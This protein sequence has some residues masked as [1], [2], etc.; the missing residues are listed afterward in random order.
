M[1][2]Y[3][4]RRALPFLVLALLYVIITLLFYSNELTGDELRHV[5][6]ATN[7][8]Q[9]YFT[10]ANNPE[11]GNGPGYPLV[12]A[13]F[14]AINTGF[15]TLKLLNVIFVLI[16]IVYLKKTME[17]FTKEKYAIFFA[18]LVGLY[19]P[20][21][22]FIPQLYSEPLSFMII[23]A[24]A[25]HIFKLYQSEKIN[26]NQ[27]IITS[28]Y[29][30]FLVLVK[31]IFLQVIALSALIL[32]VLF[33]WKKNRQNL[34]AGLVL[35]GAFVLIGPY[36]IY[37]YSITGKPFYLGTGGG[38][39]LYHRSTPYENEWGNWFSREDI[40]GGEASTTNRSRTYKDLKALSK[41]HLDFYRQLEPL[42]H[43]QRDSVFKAKA[44][45]N[46]KEHPVKYLKNTVSNIGRLLFHYPFSYRDQNLN[47]FGY[48][49]PNMFIVVLLI[50]S[51]YPT[52]RAKRKIPYEIKALVTFILIYACGIVLSEGRGRNFIIMVPSLVLFMA[53]VGTNFLKIALTKTKEAT[54]D[55]P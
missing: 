21:L 10:D 25:Y 55:V 13:P 9:G 54:T 1:S 6:Y 37:T 28:F 7:L 39:I 41:N 49:I 44:I 43:I 53:Y 12:L 50:L 3:S 14:L 17:F 16:G 18:T 52:L 24:L 31:I 11:L 47:A 8:T 34:K 19:P 42:S 2:W 51:I 29:L 26:W 45:S 36:L 48:M 22:R 30:G 46:M 35:I 23:C 38:E 15:L 32:A 20:L 27:M 4:N 33:L 40:L 5:R